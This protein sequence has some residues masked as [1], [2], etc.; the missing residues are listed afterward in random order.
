MKSYQPKPDISLPDDEG[1]GDPPSPATPVAGRPEQTRTETE[2][3]PRPARRH[4]DAGISFRGETRSDA[5]HVPT[6]GPDARLCRKAP[7]TGAMRCLI[8]HALME[9][10]SG[11]I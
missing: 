11:L 2:P 1:P 8:G 3:M 9:N 10:R 7:G 4:R 5:T 6:T